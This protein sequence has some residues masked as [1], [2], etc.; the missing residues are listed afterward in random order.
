MANKPERDFKRTLRSQIRRLSVAGYN[1]TNSPGDNV[2]RGKMMLEVPGAASAEEEGD[3]R[4]L[5]ELYDEVR[6]IPRSRVGSGSNKMFYIGA[7][8]GGKKEEDGGGESSRES[9]PLVMSTASSVSAGATSSTADSGNGGSLRS[10][11]SAPVSPVPPSC[12]APSASAPSLAALN[13]RSLN[14]N[15]KLG[16]N[17]SSSQL[18]RMRSFNRNLRR[19]R[20]FRGARESSR[21]AAAPNGN[22]N[23][24]SVD[25]AA[26]GRRKE[27]TFAVRRSQTGRKGWKV[28]P[29]LDDNLDL[30]G[31]DAAAAIERVMAA[32]R[33]VEFSGGGVPDRITVRL[34]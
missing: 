31:A 10:G 29:E 6:P 7:G 34:D 26:A 24:D 13:K 22:N 15:A 25:N 17:S 12:F 8:D 27:V 11:C 32:I 1:G 20:S 4:E 14:K 21:A 2:G 30:R 9:S 23:R 28:M 16:N 19:A 18:D 33:D 3:E 5:A